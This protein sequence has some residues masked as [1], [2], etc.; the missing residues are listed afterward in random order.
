MTKTTAKACGTCSL[1]SSYVNSDFTNISLWSIVLI[2]G[3]QSLKFPEQSAGENFAK[4]QKTS[5]PHKPCTDKYCPMKRKEE[6][7]KHKQL[8]FQGRITHLSLGKRLKKVFTLI[9]LSRRPLIIF[10]SSYCKQ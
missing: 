3:C 1:H 4:L 2:S 6:S 9:E 8:A 10:S 5:H 7:R